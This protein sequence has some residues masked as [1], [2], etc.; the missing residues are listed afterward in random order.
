MK[1]LAYVLFVISYVAGFV[2]A[3]KKDVYSTMIFFA[4]A[5]IIAVFY[6]KEESK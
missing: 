2:M 5:I 3:I 6:S 4:S 1:I